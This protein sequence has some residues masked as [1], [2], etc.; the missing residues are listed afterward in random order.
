MSIEKMPQGSPM[1]ATDPLPKIDQPC[2][3]RQGHCQ[4][5][6]TIIGDT[7]WR[8]ASQTSQEGIQSLRSKAE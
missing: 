5:L 7:M 8:K 4:F 1:Q 2:I 3:S 6:L